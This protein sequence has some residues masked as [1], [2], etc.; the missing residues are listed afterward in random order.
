MVAGVMAVGLLGAGSLVMAAPVYAEPGDASAVGASA[1]IDVD[2]PIVGFDVSTSVGGVEVSNPGSATSDEQDYTLVDLALADITLEAVSSSA[3][4]DG[5]GSE[6][7]ADVAGVEA[8]LLGLDLLSVEAASAEATC[9]VDG[10]P[11]AAATLIGLDV[12]GDA[13]AV[14]AD[15][16]A[17]VVE[18]VLGADVGGVDLSGVTVTVTV[19]HVEEVT[20]GVALAVALIATVTL[21][22]EF[23]GGAFDAAVVASVT[24]AS[25]ACEAPAVVEITATD[26][27]PE[28]GPTSGGQTVTIV[29]T[30]FGPDTTVTFGNAP[31][32]EVTVDP[33]GTSL[34]AVTPAGTEGPVT[35]TVANP[36]SS[37]AL[38]YTY[39]QPV[40]ATLT[41]TTGPTYGG[42]EVTITGQGLGTTEGVTFGGVPATIVSVDPDGGSV[43][44]LAPAGTGTVDVELTLAG[45]ATVTADQEFTYIAPVVA[46]I[47]P[48][49]GP[50]AGGTQVVISGEGLGGATGVTIDG[51]PATIVGTPTDNEIV[52]ITP[53]GTGG[54]ADVVVELPGDDLVITDGFVYIPVPA[55]TGSDPG[56]GPTTGGTPVNVTGSGFL[57]GVTS[58]TICGVTIPAGQVT[59]N[60]DGTRLRFVTPACAAGDTTIT[61]NSPGGS[62]NPLGFRYTAAGSGTTG[63]GSLA[64]TGAEPLPIAAAAGLLMG[65]GLLP[66]LVMKRRRTA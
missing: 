47:A 31:A 1:V 4:S 50:V 54:P 6:A 23:A 12:L 20:D 42:T 16:P 21:D 61:V 41:P 33:T 25:A 29:G 65:L 3:F 8:S 34:T 64:D 9:P 62:S 58:V 48:G 60:A 22:G 49:E 27:T 28:S 15:D 46:E 66:I 30:G 55:V 13:V 38:D 37:A 10:A 17:V 56:R 5:S 26:I 35:V 43:V 63:G 51:A 53:P 18:G 11:T 39:V 45:G 44:V 32:T 57:P 24:L 7:S 19:S 59:V 36:G 14:D 2:I 40:A 52:I